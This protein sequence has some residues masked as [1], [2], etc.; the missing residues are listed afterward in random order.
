[1]SFSDEE[2][3]EIY[4]FQDVEDTMTDLEKLRAELAAEKEARQAAEEEARKLKEEAEAARK[5]RAEAEAKARRREVENFVESG[6]KGGKILPAW[7]DAGLVD[8]MLALDDLTQTYEFAEGKEETPGQW[9]RDFIASFS[10]H[11]LFTRMVKPKGDD[12]R[13]E[14]AAYAEDEKVADEIASAHKPGS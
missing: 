2:K 14:D 9:F 7:K 11:P 5:A 8:F 1:V 13:E 6:L 10:E 4:E 12:S 3:Q